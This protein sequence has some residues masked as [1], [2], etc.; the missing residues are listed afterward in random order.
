M[1]LLNS[2]IKE[3]L[4]ALEVV[5][6]IYSLSK[7]SSVHY[8][9]AIEKDLASVYFKERAND[10]F[11]VKKDKKDKKEKVEESFLDDL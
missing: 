10:L 2:K 11:K 6:T 9:S 3:D 5:K 8:N 4:N 1:E 7:L